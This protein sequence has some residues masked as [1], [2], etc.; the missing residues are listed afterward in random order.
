MKKLTMSQHAQA[1][2]QQRGI[3][4]GRLAIITQFGE[5]SY[6]GKGGIRCFMTKKAMK[7]LVRT[8]GFT[9][10]IDALAGCYAVISAT[11]GALITVAHRY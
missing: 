3:P 1:R 11:D 5:R 4:E 9:Q 6:D 2:A 8:L 7:R 10:Q